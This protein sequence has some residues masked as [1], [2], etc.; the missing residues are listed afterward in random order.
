[1]QNACKKYK[2]LICEKKKKKLHSAEAGK[3]DFGIFK[4][5]L[6]KSL[7]FHNAEELI[8]SVCSHMQYSQ[9]YT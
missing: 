7:A 6:L 9:F 1:M 3:Q 5:L 2:F 8:K 4:Y